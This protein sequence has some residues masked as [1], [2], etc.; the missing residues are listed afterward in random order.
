LGNT[1]IFKI[2]NPPKFW[3]LEG[4]YIVVTNDTNDTKISDEAEI[5]REIELKLPECRN[6]GGVNTNIHRLWKIS[7][8]AEIEGGEQCYHNTKRRGG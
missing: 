4:G 3:D 2:L 8:N 6:M 5:K 1:K 7:Q